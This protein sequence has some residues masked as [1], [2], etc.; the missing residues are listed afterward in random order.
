M[1]LE[2][3]CKASSWILWGQTW[4]KYCPSTVH[5]WMM[6]N[7]VQ[8]PLK[9]QDLCSSFGQATSAWPRAPGTQQAYWGNWRLSE[10]I[11]VYEDGGI[12]LILILMYTIMYKL[13]KYMCL[14]IY[15]YI[16]KYSNITECDY[17]EHYISW[18]IMIYYA[19]I[20]II[21]TILILIMRRTRRQKNDVWLQWDEDDQEVKELMANVTMFSWMGY[22]RREFCEEIYGGFPWNEWFFSSKLVELH[23]L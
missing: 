6:L 7:V 21:I 17:D 13:I 10:E 5:S 16:Y 22:G 12:I 8:E 3:W 1:F 18:Y 23:R 19:I 11:S 9:I 20:I 4:S 2:F 15:V 14:H